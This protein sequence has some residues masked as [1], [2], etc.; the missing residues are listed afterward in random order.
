[1]IE[2]SSR[3]SVL[4]EW[5]ILAGLMALSLQPTMLGRVVQDWPLFLGFNALVMGVSAALG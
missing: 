1:M 5:G 3:Q 2:I 4:A